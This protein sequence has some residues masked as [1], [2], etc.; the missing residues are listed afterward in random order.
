V[1]NSHN[2]IEELR[3][4]CCNN[5]GT[6]FEATVV[7]NTKDVKWKYLW[8]AA[9]ECGDFKV[10]SIDPP[11]AFWSHPHDPNKSDFCGTGEHEG[12]IKLHA[13][14]MEYVDKEH[15]YYTT[16]YSCVDATGSPSVV[17]PGSQCRGHREV[18]LDQY[19]DQRA[20]RPDVSILPKKVASGLNA[21]PTSVF[22][23]S[24]LIFPFY[25]DAST[26]LSNTPSWDDDNSFS[27]SIYWAT[28]PQ[29]FNSRLTGEPYNSTS[30]ID[31]NFDVPNSALLFN[32]SGTGTN[33]YISIAISDVL[34]KGP[35]NATLDG[36]PIPATTSHIEGY[37]IV[38]IDNINYSTHTLRVSGTDVRSQPTSTPSKPTQSVTPTPTSEETKCLPIFVLLLLGFVAMRHS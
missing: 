18:H 28:D 6:D 29:T 15:V 1:G 37:S 21:P 12:I 38:K 31:F 35:F 3:A 24:Q 14:Y 4:T 36:N 23:E 13:I 26:W 25:P 8:H 11:H 7:P 10:L 32:L 30:V 27:A 20:F 17:I 16:F 2:P 5:S 34:L 22:G 9:I 19:L 33:G